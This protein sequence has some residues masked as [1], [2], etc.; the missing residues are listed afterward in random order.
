MPLVG[1][2]ACAHTPQLLL[3]PPTE[4][5][6]LV[7]RVHAAFAEVRRRLAALRCDA[8]AVIAGDHIEGFFLDAVPA[9]AVFVGS[10]AAGEF[11]GYRYRL[12]A[13]E[14]LARAVLEAGIERGFDLVYSQEVALDYAFYVPLHFTMP[15]PPHP[16][17]PIVPLYVN[18]YLPPQPT[19]RRCYAWGEAL[20]GIL[21]ARPE[22]VALIASGGMSHFP[23]TDRY[24]A[25]DYD[26]DRRLLQALG[27]GRGRE[28]ARLTGEELDKSGNVELRTWITLLGAVGDARAELLCYEPSWHHGNA[29]LAWPVERG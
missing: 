5:R 8:L 20:R 1:A 4:D 24:A 7:L 17:I 29:V 18:V 12:P 2:F 15:E 16:V 22:R 21:D 23:G 9:L 10:E 27:E 19:P 6:E 3:R 14:P 13:H 26:F 25:P 28:A 11:G